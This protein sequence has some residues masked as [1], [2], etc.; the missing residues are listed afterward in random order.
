LPDCEKYIT[1]HGRSEEK[2]GDFDGA[3]D[4][5]ILNNP[6]PGK[7]RAGS[8]AIFREKAD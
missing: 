7:R 5:G 3:G 8:G 1:D 6:I 4:L 2:P